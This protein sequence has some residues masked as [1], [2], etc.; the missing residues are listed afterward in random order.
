MQGFQLLVDNIDLMIVDQIGKIQA[1]IETS[2]ERMLL[3]VRVPIFDLLRNNVSNEC[4][5]LLLEIYEKAKKIRSLTTCRDSYWREAHGLPCAHEF[6]IAIRDRMPIH[7]DQIH[8][9]WRQ[10]RW[11]N[12]NPII[13]DDVVHIDPNIVSLNNLMEQ[14]NNNLLSKDQIE[15]MASAYEDM[16]NPGT[17]NMR[18]PQQQVRTKGRPTKYGMRS[19]KRDPSGFEHGPGSSRPGP[20]GRP[21]KSSR[22]KGIKI[23]EP[24]PEEQIPCSQPRPKKGKVYRFKKGQIADVV[25]PFILKAIDVKSDGHCGYRA[26]AV[27]SGYTED[28]YLTIRRDMALELY[29]KRDVYEVVSIS[30]TF[31]V[32]F[33]SI[34]YVCSS[35][36]V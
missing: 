28:D 19:T 22:E 3:D 8:P 29:M 21:P 33:F 35:F 12:L 24:E 36:L 10:V 11:E 34:C 2:R 13:E 18:E 9:Y 6:F 26:L 15:R 23:E 17:T 30:F 14:M 4:F 1:S 32:I 25:R 16:I 27:V 20:R 31:L 7:L 5:E